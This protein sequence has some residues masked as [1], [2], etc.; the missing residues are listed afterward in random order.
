M[1]GRGLAGVGG[2]K[3]GQERDECDQKVFYTCKKLSKN[4]NKKM[5]KV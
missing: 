2:D 5:V 3:R 4:A 1:G